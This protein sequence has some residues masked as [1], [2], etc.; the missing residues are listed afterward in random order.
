MKLLRRVFSVLCLL[1]GGSSLSAQTIAPP[2][3]VPAALNFPATAIGNVSAPLTVALQP[4]EVGAFEARL[5]DPLHFEIVEDTCTQE[6]LQIGE[7]CSFTVI[8]RPDQFG[9]YASAL[10]LVDSQG[11]LINFIPMEGLGVDGS[12]I[13]SSADSPTVTQVL[14]STQ[15]LD[16]GSLDVFA[17]SELQSLTL[18]NV[19]SSDLR[20]KTITLGGDDPSSFSLVE[21]CSLLPIKAGATCTIGAIFTPMEAGNLQ[22]ALAVAGNAEGAP[23]VIRLQGSGG[24]PLPPPSSG[25]CALSSPGFSPLGAGLWSLALSVLV[26]G[27]RHRIK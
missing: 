17:A 13:P 12:F 4:G 22:G 3:F 8:F 7:S 6:P 11:Q 1:C 16:F 26:L 15:A 23:I 24:S 5:G 25:G 20:V 14:L 18:S 2:S 9:H 19:G 10:A 27:F 21:T